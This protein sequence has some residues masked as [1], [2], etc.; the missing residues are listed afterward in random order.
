MTLEPAAPEAPGGDAAHL[1]V[2][3]RLRELREASGVSMRALATQLGISPSALS[4][5]ER[6]VMQPSVNRLVEIV[7]A[8]DVPLAS[9]FDAS[10]S[11]NGGAVVARA[12]QTGPVELA[13]GVTYRRLSPVPITGA[14]V[15]E[16]TY[17]P[18]A[19]SSQHDRMLVHRGRE[20]GSVTAGE[21]T[22]VVGGER[23]VLGVGDSITFAATTP[24]RVSNDGDVVAVAFWLTLHDV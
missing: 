1:P 10:A 22:V 12:G 6:G 15:F 20:V 19:A 14:E 3:P 8:L 24:H 9:V 21:L 5:I 17:P 7:T 16:S 11:A 13:D 18:G 2:G 23:Y 4:Q